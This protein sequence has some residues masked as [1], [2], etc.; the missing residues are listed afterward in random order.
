VRRR[1]LRAAMSKSI[2]S[3]SSSSNSG[4]CDPSM[5]STRS[6]FLGSF[7]R[8]VVCSCCCSCTAPFLSLS[9]ACSAVMVLCCTGVMTNRFAGVNFLNCSSGFCSDF[10]AGFFALVC[11]CIASALRRLE[12]GFFDFC[13]EGGLGAKKRCGEGVWVGIMEAT[14]VDLGPFCLRAQCGMLVKAWCVGGD[15]KGRCEAG[16]YCRKRGYAQSRAEPTQTNKAQNLSAAEPYA[17]R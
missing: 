15:S 5:L 8:G 3:S 10:C 14:W 1:L 17:V 9:F 12:C 16:A 6:N 11:A 7:G 13:V 4:S 2:S